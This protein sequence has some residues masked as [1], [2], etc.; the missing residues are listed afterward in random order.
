VKLFIELPDRTTLTAIREN[1]TILIDHGF[2]LKDIDFREGKMYFD[3]DK[4][5]E[6]YL[7]DLVVLE[8]SL[9]LCIKISD[10]K[11]TE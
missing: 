4:E 1:E 8:E 3:L 2:I 5:N 6:I 9:E 10:I 7:K 11:D